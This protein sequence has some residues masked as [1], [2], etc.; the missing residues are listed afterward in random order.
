VERR[1]AERFPCDLQPFW[2]EWGSGQGESSAARVNNISTTG[3]SLDTP[4]RIRPGSVLV[5][6]LLSPERGLSRPLLVRVIHSS[7]QP[8]GR[9]LSGGAFVRRLSDS[10]LARMLSAGPAE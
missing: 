2:T 8:D 4:V 10:E 7:A 3:I 5:L 6:K 1:G 9:W